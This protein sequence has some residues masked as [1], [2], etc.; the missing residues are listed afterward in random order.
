M[1]FKIS[2]IVLFVIM[3]LLSCNK[4]NRILPS[5]TKY[6]KYKPIASMSKQRTMT[7]YVSLDD[8]QTKMDKDLLDS[9][10][11]RQFIIED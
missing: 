5:K 9:K 8:L 3:T 4:E 11:M 7:Y 10:E 6:E 1:Y 2:S